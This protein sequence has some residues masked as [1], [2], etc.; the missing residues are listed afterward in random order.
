MSAPFRR[1]YLQRSLAELRAGVTGGA[2]GTGVLLA[3]VVKLVDLCVNQL[4]DDL[5]EWRDLRGTRLMGL[6][7][8]LAVPETFIVAVDDL[9]VP[10][11]DAGVTV[12]E[13]LVGVSR[14]RSSGFMVILPRL[15][16]LPGRLYVAWKFDVKAWDRSAH[17]VMLPAG[18][19]LSQSDYVSPITNGK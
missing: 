4:V 7:E 10:N 5:H 8:D 18:R 6:L 9:V 13:E 3:V 17:D 15:K 19:L 11:T 2:R 14:N 16:A 12:L 1:E